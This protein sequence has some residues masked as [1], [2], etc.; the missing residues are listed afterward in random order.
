MTEQL[1]FHFSL[2]CIGEGN[3]N[4]LQCSCLENPRDR[5]AW[6]T[7]IYGVA[8]SRTRLKWLS[9][10]K[11]FS[12]SHLCVTKYPLF[13]HEASGTMI[14]TQLIVTETRNWRGLYPTVQG[15]VPLS[16]LLLFRKLTSVIFGHLSDTVAAIPHFPLLQTLILI[17]EL[18]LG[19][20]QGFLFYSNLAFPNSV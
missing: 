6:W 14:G 13:S 2:S 20:A 7:D 3:G 10:N 16:T 19:Q 15:I 9:S 4:P 1:H 5:G 18:S 12:L 11:L 8:Q 17:H